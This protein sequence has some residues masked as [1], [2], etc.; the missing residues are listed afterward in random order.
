M[1]L[2]LEH[3]HANSCFQPCGVVN[4]CQDPN[5]QQRNDQSTT[6]RRVSVSKSRNLYCVRSRRH[7][8][9]SAETSLEQTTQHRAYNNMDIRHKKRTQQVIATVVDGDLRPP[10][11]ILGLADHATEEEKKCTD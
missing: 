10:G 8:P 9:Y 6:T 11:V 2:C 7:T 3:C 1:P 4:K 5:R